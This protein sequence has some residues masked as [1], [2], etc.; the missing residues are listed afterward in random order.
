MQ[1]GRH[2]INSLNSHFY[3]INR[4][5]ATRCETVRQELVRPLKAKSS[6]SSPDIATKKLFRTTWFGIHQERLTSASSGIL[7]LLQ[8]DFDDTQRQGSGR[9]R[10]GAWRVFNEG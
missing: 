8:I 9:L 3:C 6:G 10:E 2:T 4:V 5:Y 7:W 1:F